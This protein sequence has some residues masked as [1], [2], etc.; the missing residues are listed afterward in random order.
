MLPMP[1]P[2]SL[3]A[4]AVE[5]DAIA[6]KKSKQAAH[7]GLSDTARAYLLRDAD[8]AREDA[9]SK[10]A[11]AARILQKDVE[12]GICSPDGMLVTTL[13]RMEQDGLKVWQGYLKEIGSVPWG[14]K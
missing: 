13:D 14:Q 1:T 11:K 7:P 6:V 3:E 5:L 4:E 2:E 8:Y 10:R 9:A 12:A